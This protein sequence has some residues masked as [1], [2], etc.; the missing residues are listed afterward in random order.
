MSLSRLTHLDA[1]AGE[2]RKVNQGQGVPDKK[3]HK[4]TYTH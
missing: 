3:I 4:S 2:L 1:M